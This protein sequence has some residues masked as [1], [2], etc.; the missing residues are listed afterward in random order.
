MV[1]LQ[2]MRELKIHADLKNLAE[3]IKSAGLSNS[4]PKENGRVSL[5]F[6]IALVH[7]VPPSEASDDFDYLL[8]RVGIARRSRFALC[9]EAI[10]LHVQDDI[11]DWSSEMS[12]N[13]V[14]STIIKLS[15]DIEHSKVF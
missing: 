15:K 2:E 4:F 7:G 1:S 13:E 3:F 9:W 5:A 12:T 10:E 6:A 14:V 8:E 11:I